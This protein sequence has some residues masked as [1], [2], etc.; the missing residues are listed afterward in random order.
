VSAGFDYF[1]RA[2]DHYIPSTART[3]LKALESNL[4]PPESVLFLGTSVLP[5][6]EDPISLAEI[7]RVLARED[8]NLDTNLLLMRVFRLLLAS[9]NPE[10]TLF[11]AESINRIESR[12]TDRI[13][14][15]K[16]RWTEGGDI[17]ALKQLSLA[18]YQLA[19]ICPPAIR[20]FYLHEAFDCIKKLQAR[21]ALQRRHVRLLVRILLDLRL[22]GQALGVLKQ[23]PLGEDPRF[24]LLEAEV[25]FQLRNLPRVRELCLQL[26]QRQE[27]LEESVRRV[28]ELWTGD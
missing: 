2:G 19:Q 7:E 21:K 24:L 14:S 8:L 25:E 12:Y 6:D 13:E 3:A 15:L 11:A 4:V 27:H 18:Y 28:L 10:I 26:R 5:L 20:N 22:P 9:P 16:A 1:R 17:E 23:L